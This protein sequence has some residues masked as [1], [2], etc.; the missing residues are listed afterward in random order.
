MK[1]LI[2]QLGIGNMNTAGNQGA[3][4]LQPQTFRRAQRAEV[5]GLQAQLDTVLGRDWRA[6]PIRAAFSSGAMLFRDGTLR[7]NRTAR[8]DAG[9]EIAARFLLPS[10]QCQAAPGL[11]ERDFFLAKAANALLSFRMNE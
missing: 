2:S 4:A 10:R 9:G 1:F 6:A 7:V 11:R 8:C 3:S 5:P